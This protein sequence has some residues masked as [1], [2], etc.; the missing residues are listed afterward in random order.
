VNLGAPMT[1]TVPV[2]LPLGAEIIS[3]ELLATVATG[4][5][6]MGVG[7]AWRDSY[8]RDWGQYVTQVSTRV[9]PSGPEIWRVFPERHVVATGRAYWLQLYM[10]GGSPEAA[11]ASRFHG[12][13]ITYGMPGSDF[14][15]REVHR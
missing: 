12:V 13:R 7:L 2:T 10:P 6:G 4:G 9:S 11:G 3:V 5:N 15:T 8:Q 14:G 1:W